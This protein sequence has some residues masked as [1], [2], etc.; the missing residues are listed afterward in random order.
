LAEGQARA[1]P[2]PAE[3]PKQ[4]PNAKLKYSKWLFWILDLRGFG[5]V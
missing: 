1:D 5:F 3:Y 4:T 2:P